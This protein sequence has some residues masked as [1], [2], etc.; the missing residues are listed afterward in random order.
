MS[1]FVAIV[2][3]C[4]VLYNCQ[5]ISLPYRAF[6]PRF[7]AHIVPAVVSYFSLCAFVGSPWSE[8]L[9]S[10][11]VYVCVCTIR[12]CWSVVCFAGVFINV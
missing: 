2:Y 12:V 9:F 8:L 1:S 5:R 3:E 11:C 4:D 10:E 6:Y 7:I